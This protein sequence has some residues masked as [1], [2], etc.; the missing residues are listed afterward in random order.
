[1]KEVIKVIKY[2]IPYWR[3]SL[4]NIFFNILSI[5]ASLFSF[6]LLIP[7]LQILFNKSQLIT[8]SVP[9]EF[10][11]K[12]LNH[13]FYYFLSKIIMENGSFTAL[14]AVSLFIV[15]ATL[16]K[17][18]FV[19]LAMYN[20]AP[21]MNGTVR[22]FQTNIYS[23]ILSLPLSYF[24][25]ERKG[26][27]IARFTSDVQE[28]KF[29]V[30]AS[31]EMLFRDPIMILLY[32]TYLFYSSTELTFFVLI[33]IPFVGLLIGQLGKSLKRR[34]MQARITVGEILSILEE[35]LGGLRI[36]KAF[37]SEKRINHKFEEKNEYLYKVMNK[38]IRKEFLS[39]P[40]SEFLATAVIIIIIIYGGNLILNKQSDLTSEAFIAYIVVFSQVLNPAKSLS[41]AYYNIQKGA[42]SIDRVDKILHSF[43]DII[44]K[45]NPIRFSTFE[46]K[47]EYKNI[48]FKYADEF[49]L[50]NI[51]LELTKGKTIALVGQSG[52]GKSTIADLLPRFYNVTEGEILIDDKNI[53]DC[54]IFDL[55][56]LM[57]IVNQEAILFNDSI[58]NNITFGVENASLEEVENAAKIANAHEFI[59]QTENS[60]QTNI[61]DRGSKLSGGQ[62]QRLSIARAVL[63]NPPILILD[64]ATSALDTE[65]ERLVQE[66]ITNLMKNRTSIVIAH[67]LSTI[68]NA[69]EIC[70][71]H[72]G[73]I[74]ERGK[75][76]ELLEVGGTYKKLHDLQMF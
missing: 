11:I 44:E 69:D 18:G 49:V 35:T 50:R 4:L 70:V 27:L 47:I 55:R 24:S 59:I 57:G 33:F 58:F 23:K 10:S 53:N 76:D 1:M 29:T 30:T 45:E 34:S 5:I 6:T 3:H 71:L 46:E 25:N 73:R 31:L 15:G 19:Y 68:K 65:S 61:G 16:L 28:I 72:E 63:K 40:V 22:D 74:I 39:H 26:D 2:S 51:D 21:I 36:I 14:M 60:Y 54:S 62:R 13:N 32:V 9:F 37:N 8:K 48:S 42:A 52:S 67:R 17:T 12:S 66:A 38:V 64:E 56:N 41:K 7:F 43:S 20:L 75:H